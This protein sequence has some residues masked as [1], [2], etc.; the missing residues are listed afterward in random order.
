MVDRSQLALYQLIFSHFLP[1]ENRVFRLFCYSVFRVS[2]RTFQEVSPPP[3]K[4]F[5][6]PPF[7]RSF[8]RR[9]LSGQFFFL[10]FFVPGRRR[11]SSPLSLAPPGISAPYHD[12]LNPLLFEMFF[13]PASCLAPCPPCTRSLFLFQPPFIFRSLGAHPPTRKPFFSVPRFFPPVALGKV[14]DLVLLQPPPWRT[15]LPL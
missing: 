2:S 13:L 12:L 14:A 15:L 4:V 6:L 3:S 8:D 5:L 10:F 11:L 7:L 1:R 9:P